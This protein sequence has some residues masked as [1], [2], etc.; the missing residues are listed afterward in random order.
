MINESALLESKS[1]RDSVLER[2]DVLDR[3][4]ALSLLP[5]GMHVTTAMV[6]AYFGVGLTAITSLVHDHRE[7]LDASGYRVLTGTELNSFKEV[8]GIQSRSRS[9]ALFSRRAVL[10]VAMLLRDSKVARQVR[11][12]LLDMEYLVRTQPVE[13]SAPTAPDDLDTRIDQRITHILGKTIVPMFNALIESSGEHRRELIALRTGVQRIERSLRRHSIRLQRLEGPHGDGANTDV[14]S[15]IDAMSGREFEQ[16]VAELL[17][18]DGCTDVVVQGGCG[19]RG[20]DITGRTPDGRRVA[21]QCK[22]FAPGL[23]I[24]SSDMQ[25]FV[26]AAKV[27][28]VSEVALFVATCHFTR[29]ALKVATAGGVTAVQRGML[30]EWSTGKP[31]QILL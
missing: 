30:A 3:V 12:Y 10:N 8:S 16:H 22:R 4:K 5:D 18:L 25:K 13:N 19:D 17:H 6:A 15:S 26:G 11:V 14:M 27:L 20:V 1:L 7:E 2:T 31:L 29:E 28:H 23:S 24:T 9:L 21:V